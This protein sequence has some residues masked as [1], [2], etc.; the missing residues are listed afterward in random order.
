MALEAYDFSLFQER[1]ENTAPAL[2][3]KVIEE[4]SRQGRVVEL[5]QQKPEG[6]TQPQRRRSP[7]KMMAAALCFGL[8]FITAISAVHSEVQLTEL[9]EAINTARNDLGEA[10]SRE[11]QLSMQ[12]AQRMT[13]AQVEEYATK[14]GMSKL[15]GAQVTYM[16]VSREDQGK[17][18][19][20][21]EGGSALDK[22]LARVRAWLAG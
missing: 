18:V 21:I 10:E 4:P 6:Q 13:D 11:V 22:L 7:L 19:Q 3:P 8:I 14:M 17:V 1:V 9:T 15:T 2:D 5:P 12:A 16:H 20:D